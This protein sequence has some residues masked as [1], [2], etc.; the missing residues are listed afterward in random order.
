MTLL[1]TPL[2][3]TKGLTRQ[4]G[5]IR[6]VNDVSFAL[7]RGEIRGVIGPNGAGKTTLVGMICG[8]VMPSAGSVH[9]AGAEITHL[10]P[11]SRVARGIVYTFQIT[12]VFKRLTCRANVALAAQRQLT[13]SLRCRF[14][15]SQTALDAA[16]D[17]ALA[18]V[19]LS[20]EGDRIAG[21]LPYG[22]QRLL[23]IAMGLALKPSLL[24]LDEPTQGLAPGDIGP[25]CDL[26][27]ETAKST[28]ILFIEHNL[29]VVLEL[30][31]RV[32][33]MNQGAILAEG[34]PAEIEQ[35]PAVQQAY[36]GD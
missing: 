5:G 29:K 36:L 10:Q 31:D 24:I 16:I 14:A 13:T 32:T 20:E 34:T 17:E 3:Q 11:W 2:L 7:E 33:V 9:F 22:H 12:S 6:A 23:E 26:I 18:A 1:Q 21:E 35:H 4:F 8:R 19:G 25:F 28:T 27:R 30:A 15:L